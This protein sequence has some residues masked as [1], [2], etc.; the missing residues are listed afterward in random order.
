VVYGVRRGLSVASKRLGIA[1]VADLVEFHA[2]ADR[3][4]PYPVE[5]KRGKPKLRYYY[6]GANWRRRVQHAGAK[7]AVD[8]GGT[9]IVE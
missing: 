6:L 3:E 5:F 1:G 7:P 8:L 9:L 2:A 4:I